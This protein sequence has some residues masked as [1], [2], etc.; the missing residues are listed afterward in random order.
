MHFFMTRIPPKLLPI[1]FQA[2]NNCG[3]GPDDA[4]SAKAVITAVRHSTR[5][6]IKPPVVR[7]R[8]L[9]FHSGGSGAIQTGKSLRE[10]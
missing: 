5:L 9:I 7:T 2:R 4:G 10:K 1:N 3:R 8:A 6:Y